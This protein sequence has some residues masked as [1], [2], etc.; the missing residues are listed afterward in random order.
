MGQRGSPRRAAPVDRL[1]YEGNSE[2]D[3]PSYL[4]GK[5]FESLGPERACGP[6]RGC[7]QQ[8]GYGEMKPRMKSSRLIRDSEIAIE[9]LELMAQSREAARHGRGIAD[10]VVR[11]QEKIEGGFD[12]RR[13]CGAGTLGRFCQPRGHLLGEIN[14]NSGFHGDLA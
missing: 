3:A 13:F 5:F 2:I 6:L 10:V 14:A 9:L 4:R 11:A 1:A 8:R 7:R 12:E